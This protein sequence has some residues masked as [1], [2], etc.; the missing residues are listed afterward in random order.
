MQVLDKRVNSGRVDLF[1]LLYD[2]AKDVGT[3]GVVTKVFFN[4]LP[5]LECDGRDHSLSNPS[6]I[7]AVKVT[8]RET[9][10]SSIP[11]PCICKGLD[12]LGYFPIFGCPPVI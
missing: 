4:S 1:L 8:D 11:D 10:S 12:P 9:I 5:Y 2:G 6:K 7:S 3:R